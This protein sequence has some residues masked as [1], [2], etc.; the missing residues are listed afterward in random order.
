MTRALDRC[1][2]R[3]HLRW[4]APGIESHDEKG[5]F[6]SRDERAQAATASGSANDK[7]SN[8]IISTYYIS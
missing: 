8:K 3:C 1:Q 2:T 6:I 7:I 5:S 4:V